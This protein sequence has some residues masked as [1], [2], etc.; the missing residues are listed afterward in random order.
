VD[1]IIE[2][3]HR[4]APELRSAA[5]TDTDRAVARLIAAEIEDGACLQVGIGAMPNAVCSL[6]LNSGVRNLGVHTEMLTDGIVDLYKAG[7]VTGAAKQAQPG[8]MVCSFGLG[9]QAMY[10]AIDRNPDILCCPVDQTNLPHVITRNDRVVSINNTTQMDLQGQAASESDG[11]RHISGTGG[12][13]QFVRAAYAS[14]GGKSFVC[15]ASTYERHGVRKSRIVLNLTPG[16]VVTTARSDIMYVVTEFGMVNL[17][18]KSV[19]ERAQAMISIAHPDF[20]E[21]LAREAREHG[22]IPRGFS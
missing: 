18:G 10:A 16:N 20:R 5:P 7:I 2:G 12:Q 19:A 22:L 14:K 6:L 1:Y 9:S 13:L 17:K 4:P 3:D 8:K 15:L 11:H 21:E